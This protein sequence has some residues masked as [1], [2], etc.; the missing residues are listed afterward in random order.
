M[1][2]CLSQTIGVRRLPELE[3]TTKEWIAVCEA[4]P[5]E[6]I[7]ILWVAFEAPNLDPRLSTFAD[8]AK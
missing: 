1:P 3:Q 2:R 6:S 7:V 8:L 4:I 5:V